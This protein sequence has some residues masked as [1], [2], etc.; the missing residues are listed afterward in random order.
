M[1]SST[2]VTT[3]LLALAL[4]GGVVAA[5]GAAETSATP[6]ADAWGLPGD[7]DQQAIEQYLDALDRVALGLELTV[8]GNPGDTSP[9]GPILAKYGSVL[10]ILAEFDS[11][12]LSAADR[13]DGPVIT[14]LKIG[15]KSGEVL[16][17]G[18]LFL[19]EIHDGKGVV[20][21]GEDGEICLG[22]DL[23]IGWFF[24]KNFR[25]ELCVESLETTADGALEF[26][27]RRRGLLAK[28][29]MPELR[30][31]PEGVVEKKGLPILRWIGGWKPLDKTADRVPMP[32]P[33]HEWPIHLSDL[34]DWLPVVEQAKAAAAEPA[35]APAVAPATAKEKKAIPLSALALRFDSQMDRGVVT[36]ADPA[37]TLEFSKHQIRLEV[38]GKF[39]G[40]TFF[41]DPERKSTLVANWT[42][43]GRVNDDS[44]GR[45]DIAG[46]RIELDGGLDARLPLD[47]IDQ[48]QAE[49]DFGA[50]IDLGLSSM[51]VRTAE[52][53][54]I[55]MP[56]GLTG[57]IRGNGSAR[58]VAGE[59]TPQVRLSPDSGLMLRIPG[60]IVLDRPVEGSKL[61]PTLELP[62]Q[63][64]L[65]SAAAD[66]ALLSVDGKVGSGSAVD[67]AAGSSRNVM[68]IDAGFELAGR[69]GEE[70]GLRT[71]GGLLLRFAAG[72]GIGLTGTANAELGFAGLERVTGARLAV[73]LR[74]PDGGGELSLRT[75]KGVDIGGRI[76]G[77]GGISVDTGPMA[78]SGGSTIAAPAGKIAAN[79]ALGLGRGS[80]PSAVIGDARLG[81]EG[82]FALRL[83]PAR[84]K[85]EPPQPLLVGPVRA[86]MALGLDLGAGS[87][88]RPADA[89]PIVFKDPVRFDLGVR[90]AIEPGAGPGNLGAIE[91]KIRQPI[92]V[93]VEMKPK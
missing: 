23:E 12:G 92:G 71:P 67:A 18:P 13:A 20:W 1:R 36:L 38:N 10:E 22:L 49:V 5:A 78:S 75:A 27:S 51:K 62:G 45:L 93:D 65:S 69:G 63:L 52:G 91:I 26:N 74:L 44:L 70:F 82:G 35:T 34:L 17:L 90:G 15:P 79:L 80:A 31:S 88:Y 7:L 16:R 37:A 68:V 76:G 8:G 81:V 89:A 86:D 4:I 2:K 59:K 53:I 32:L 48:R 29:V 66:R 55:A 40:R 72:A 47:E 6:P 56:S 25:E 43:A 3:A 28:W 11:A 33:V 21:L 19:K 58:L 73:D 30:I 83:D 61:P 39:D 14:K 60:P 77:G 64:T 85:A 41:T 50:S 9:L 24:K 46:I 42:V 84:R 54:A 57:E 87:S